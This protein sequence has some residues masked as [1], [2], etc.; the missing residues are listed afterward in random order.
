[1]GI[2]PGYIPRRGSVIEVITGADPSAGAEIT[3]TVPAGQ[4]WRLLS[5]MLTLVTDATA[6]NRRPSISISD[7]TNEIA[8]ALNGSAVQAASLTMQHYF[9]IGLGGSSTSLVARDVG[10]AAAQAALPDIILPAGFVITSDTDLI[11]S[12]DNYDVP[13]MLVERYVL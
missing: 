12:G 10:T 2:V 4:V 6:A 8:L 9:A 13:L 3:H 5:I 11:E 7:G 1:M